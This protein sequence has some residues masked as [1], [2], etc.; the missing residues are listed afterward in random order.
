[1]RLIVSEW[2]NFITLEL[3]GLGLDQRLVCIHLV[4]SKRPLDTPIF[5]LPLK[6]SGKR[7]KQETQDT[8]PVL[9]IIAIIQ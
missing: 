8:A 5:E 3:C 1:M 7:D 6:P 2:I 9:N 4:D